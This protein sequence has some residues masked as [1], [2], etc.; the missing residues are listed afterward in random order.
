MRD[1]PGLGLDHPDLHLLELL[2]LQF[3]LP[4]LFLLSEGHL[5]GLAGV[6]FEAP[7]RDGVLAALCSRVR[8][9]I[10]VAEIAAI[11]VLYH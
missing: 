7:A 5:N 10:S 9:E 1:T 8:P 11:S 2:L 6:F 4:P 3:L